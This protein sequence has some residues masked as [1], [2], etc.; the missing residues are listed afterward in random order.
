MRMK[1]FSAVI[2]LLWF[3]LTQNVF[4]FH[5]STEHMKLLLQYI[6]LPP[7]S[8]FLFLSIYVSGF[9]VFLLSCIQY[10]IIWTC[11]KLYHFWSEN[12]FSNFHKHRRAHTN[13]CYDL[14]KHNFQKVQQQQNEMTKVKFETFNAPNGTQKV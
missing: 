1:K 10:V 7:Y 12:L 9:L 11:R 6:P 5:K 3:N 14:H 13:T 2:F 8:V 4:Q